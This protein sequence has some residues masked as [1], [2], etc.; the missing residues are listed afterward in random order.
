MFPDDWLRHVFA[1]V[2]HQIGERSLSADGTVMPLCARCAGLYDGVFVTVLWYATQKAFGWKPRLSRTTLALVTVTAAVCVIDGASGA[3]HAAS[4]PNIVRFALGL[5]AGIAIG[6]ALAHHFSIAWQDRR[7]AFWLP[8]SEGLLAALTVVGT[9]VAIAPTAAGLLGLAVA[10]AMGLLLFHVL[11]FWTALDVSRRIWRDPGWLGRTWRHATRSAVPAVVATLA[12]ATRAEAQAPQ[13]SPLTTEECVLVRTESSRSALRAALET[14]SS[15]AIVVAMNRL[16]TPY[17][18][19][20][21]ECASWRLSQT[22]PRPSPTA[23][24]GAPPAPTP[25]AT[26]EPRGWHRL[27]QECIIR[28]GREALEDLESFRSRYNSSGYYGDTAGAKCEVSLRREISDP[29]FTRDARRQ[30][31]VVTRTPAITECVRLEVQAAGEGDPFEYARRRFGPPEDAP[32]EAQL[33]SGPNFQPMT[34][35]EILERFVR[36]AENACALSGGRAVADWR[37]PRSPL[38]HPFLPPVFLAFVIG[39][40]LWQKKKR[41]ETWDVEKEKLRTALLA[42]LKLPKTGDAAARKAVLALLTATKDAPGGEELWLAFVPDR[43]ISIH[44]DGR[45]TS[46]PIKT[47][48]KLDLV[49]MGGAEFGIAIETASGKTD[50]DGRLRLSG[51]SDMVRIV[52]ILIREGIAVGYRKA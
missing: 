22:D 2:C 47:L 49:E 17:Q 11:A 5:G 19:R 31:R 3:S 37:P 46:I 10:A 4:A 32:P 30:T 28:L 13:P 20:D 38:L 23:D 12:L 25:T 48:K 29:I 27:A 36:L 9:G 7:S 6:A 34:T 41:R 24:P 52:N 40:A 42:E 44:A 51:A 39:G 14:K 26:P 35:G 21:G 43:I 45:R 16:A 15:L 33:H 50:I 8:S 1:A 18:L